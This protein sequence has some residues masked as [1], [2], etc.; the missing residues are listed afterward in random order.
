MAA[1]VWHVCLSV[2]LTLKLDLYYRLCA[3][4]VRLDL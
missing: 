3:E 4:R 1:E 2:F